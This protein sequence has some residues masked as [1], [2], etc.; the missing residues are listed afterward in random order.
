[1]QPHR[2]TQT[3][4]QR[5]GR[6]YRNTPKEEIKWRHEGTLHIKNGKYVAKHIYKNLKDAIKSIYLW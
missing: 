3:R 4:H 2:D 6:T 1:P 5:D